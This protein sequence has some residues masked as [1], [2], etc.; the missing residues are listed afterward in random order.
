MEVPA[1]GQSPLTRTWVL[2][3]SYFS[4]QTCLYIYSSFTEI[5]NYTELITVLLEARSRARL[6]SQGENMVQMQMVPENQPRRGQVNQE[7][8]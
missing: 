8:C 3:K 7:G 6:A 2:W 4:R 1:A 5:F